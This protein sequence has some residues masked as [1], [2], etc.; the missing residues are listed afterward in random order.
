[1]DGNRRQKRVLDAYNNFTKNNPH[2]TNL[3]LMLGDNAYN[4]GT[5]NQYQNAVFSLIR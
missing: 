4:Q 2:H 1:M 5:D 3:W